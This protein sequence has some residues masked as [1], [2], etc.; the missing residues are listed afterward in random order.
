MAPFLD[1]GSIAFENP[2]AHGYKLRAK[3][4]EEHRQR[5]LLPSWKHIMN[6]ES[7]SMSPDEMVEATYDAAIDL[8]RVKAQA[9]VLDPVVA[10][11]TEQRIAEARVQMGRIDRIMDGPPEWI[12]PELKVLKQE[13]DRLSQSTVA[14]KSE[15]NWPHAATVKN[16]AACAGL[17]VR[18]NVAN[19]FAAG[20]GEVAPA[21]SDQN[22][23][24]A[25]S[26]AAHEA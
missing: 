2:E 24:P 17:F 16:V 25:T 9:G 7:E 3:T 19:L 6:Y 26:A 1:P 21:T 13:F 14:E 20:R 23:R 4:L 12:R 5:L 15:L 22:L 18:E 10:A 8:N 11:R